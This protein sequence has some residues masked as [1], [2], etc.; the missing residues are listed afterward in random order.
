MIFNWSEYRDICR[1]TVCTVVPT[2]HVIKVETVLFC[3]V[4]YAYTDITCTIETSKLILWY[5]KVVIS[6]LHEK[7]Y[8]SI[9]QHGINFFCLYV[10][11]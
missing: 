3:I 5:G 6:I 7:S 11:K 9:G 10:G 8:I 2:Q 1:S 4:L